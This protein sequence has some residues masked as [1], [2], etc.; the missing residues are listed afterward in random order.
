M[1]NRNYRLF[2]VLGFLLWLFGALTP[3]STLV[4]AP[5]AQGMQIAA[6]ANGTSFMAPRQFPIG[7]DPIDVL[8]GDY[9]GDQLLDVALT[10]SLSPGRIAIYAGN[11]RGEFANVSNIA[12]TNRSSQLV[13]GDFN[14]DG[15]LDLAT[16]VYG[17]QSALLIALGR[18]DWTFSTTLLPLSFVRYPGGVAT[19]DFS[20]DGKPDLLISDEDKLLLYRGDGQGAFARTGSFTT[21]TGPGALLAADFSGD[22]K[23]DVVALSQVY[24]QAPMLLLNNGQ[25]GFQLGPAFDCKSTPGVAGD[26]NNDGKTD[27]AWSNSYPL[28]ERSVSILLG[29]GG[30]RFSDPVHYPVGSYYGAQRL[31]LAELNG[32]GQADLVAVETGSNRVT[33]LL[34]NG[35][36][37]FAVRASY[38][39][40]LGPAD[41]AAGDFNRDGK[42]DLAVINYDQ[43]LSALLGQGDG[44]WQALRAFDYATQLSSPATLRDMNGDGRLDAVGGALGNFGGVTVALGDGAGGF[45][46]PKTYQVGIDNSDVAVA[47]FNQDGRPDIALTGG[48]MG[49]TGSV[50]VLLANATGDFTADPRNY[51]SGQTPSTI[52]APDLNGDGKADLVVGNFGSNDVA[53]MLGDGRGNFATAVKFPVGVS[54][55]SIAPGDFNNDGKLDLAVANYGGTTLSL[56]LGN[57]AGGFSVTSLLVPAV[58]FSLAAADFNRDGKLDLA[59]IQRDET[60]RQNL[61]ILL[62]NGDATFRPPVRYTTEPFPYSLVVGDFTGDGQLDLALT[63][64]LTLSVY[65]AGSRVSLYAGNGAGSFAR[66]ASVPAPRSVALVTGDLTND[67]LS[68]LAILTRSGISTALAA[69]LPPPTN[70]LVSVSAASYQPAALAPEAIAS[71]FGTNLAPFNASATSLPLPETLAGTRL[72][73][74]DAAGVERSVPLFFV[75]PNQI[76]YQVPPGMASGLATITVT[77]SAGQSITGVTLITPTFPGLFTANANGSGPPAGYLLRVKSNGAQTTEPLAMLDPATNRY[78]PR[79]IDFFSDPTT[80]PDQLFLVLYGTGIR[81]RS[82]LAS[83]SAWFNG[84]QEGDVVFAGKQGSLLGVDQ[85]NVRLMPG[86]RSPLQFDLQLLVDRKASNFVRLVFKE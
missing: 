46:S 85:I 60:T 2:S 13:Q 62:G 38:N 45:H 16:T 67:G 47:D 77:N 28:P 53:V 63:E 32:D 42:T 5:A 7:R 19:A 23:P 52:L 3:T 80:Q 49:D 84:V 66:A 37:A 55:T 15:K 68:D 6:C 20:G 1:M 78:V 69:C 61:S 44:Q 21:P 14:G 31:T 71:A 86:S 34:G 64:I 36:G 56:L 51:N 83:V 24:D 81:N 54:P 29:L 41:A 35:Q 76:N 27:L 75:S 74:K 43:T 40:G 17:D 4:T 25:G 18:G 9:N 58:P 57:G 82:A 26:F 30:G 8:A 72:R 50:N 12:L 10:D 48:K 70:E 79:A 59:L 11:G 22:G 33:L 39:P 73:V 65:D